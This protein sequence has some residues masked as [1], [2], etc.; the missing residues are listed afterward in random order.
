MSV[1]DLKQKLI[2]KL[3]ALSDIHVDY[4]KD[5][6]LLC[7]YYLGK[8]IAHF[9]NDRE[10]D[11]RLTPAL[12]KREKLTP[13]EQTLSHLDRSKN[14]RWIVQAFTNEQDITRV[15]ALIELAKALK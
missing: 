14:S 4:Y 7:V 12:I 9:Q 10:I 6:A 11:I 8:E 1:T 15:V 3:S 13:P 2:V 5:T